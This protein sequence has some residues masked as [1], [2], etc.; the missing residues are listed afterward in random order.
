MI[1]NSSGMPD[2]FSLTAGVIGVIAL[3]GNGN[4]GS[5]ACTGDYITIPNTRVVDPTQTPPV[6][7][8]GPRRHCGNLL[9]NI[10]QQT[11]AGVVAC[12]LALIIYYSLY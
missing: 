1:L 4:V 6:I 8:V 12:K 7:V 9:V 3:A 2:S 5:I 10:D 11:L